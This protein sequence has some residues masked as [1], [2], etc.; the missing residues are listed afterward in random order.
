MH[1][2]GRP[3]QQR[4]KDRWGGGF[5]LATI[6]ALLAAWLAGDM[7]GKLINDRNSTAENG[8]SGNPTTGTMTYTEPGEFQLRF[9]QVGAFRSKS[10]WMTA[11]REMNAAELAP[12]VGATKNNLTPVYVGPFMDKA[13]A[14]AAMAKVKS[15][16]GYDKALIREINV[17][18]NPDAV[19]AV[20]TGEKQSDLKKSMDLLNTYLQEVAVWLES[21]GAMDTAM[22]SES[23]K[24]LNDLAA[25]LSTSQDAKVKE[26]A[27]MAATA[28]A[29]ATTI[30]GIADAE[31]TSNEYQAAVSQ[32]MSLV[33][34]Y[35]AFQAGK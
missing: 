32:Y 33:D 26:M 14:E 5:I 28:S 11:V 2:F 18:Y 30:E 22:L 7:I 27:T 29:N 15:I 24:A 12:V 6:L 31:P 34:Q 21:A 4:I 23:G 17:G 19:P 8:N 25:T 16:K 9:V 1:R 10:S 13:S 20:A 3:A 35:M